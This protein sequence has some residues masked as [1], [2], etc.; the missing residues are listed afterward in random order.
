MQRRDFSYH[1]PQELIALYPAKERTQSRLLCLEGKTGAVEHKHFYQIIDLLMPGD[2]LVLNNT[3]VMPA[4]MYGK[5]LSG[6]KIEI[7]VERVLDNHRALVHCKASKRPRPN[8]QLIFDGDVTAEVLSEQNDLLEIKFN[9]P[10]S[11]TDILHRYGHI[12]LP[13]YIARDD[14]LTD[15]ERYQTVYA[16]ALGSVAAPTAGLHFDEILLEKLK[17]K[18]IDIAYITLH[19]GAGTFQNVRVENL[20][21]HIMHHEYA[22]ISEEVCENVRFAK[23]Q[24]KRVIAVGTT[25]VR[26]LETAALSG[27][28][29]SFVG[30]TNLFIRPG[31]NFHCVDAM[32]TNFHLPESTLLM[33]VSAFAGFE[34]IMRAYQIAIEQKYR[35]FSYGDAM[36]ITRCV[37]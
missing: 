36:F 16:E 13:P 19:V 30:E 1:L 37:C 4:R 14:E 18:G 2:L 28:I 7:L 20:D 23:Q 24:G 10:L 34:N 22:E 29:K 15:K 12:P 26:S 33:L 6:G 27:E 5:K 9:S 11:V 17:T 31:F 35:F 8:N 25:A 21:E 3:R 32:I